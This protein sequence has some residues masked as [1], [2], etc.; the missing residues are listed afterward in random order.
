MADQ[1]P[2]QIA[3]AKAASDAA[4]AAVANPWYHGTDADADLIGH[5]ETKGWKTLTPAAAA[6]AAAKAHREAEKMVGVPAN[7]LIR[8]PKDAS[9]IAG[10]NAVWTRLGAPT[11][12]KEY[13]FADV[14]F[15]NGDALD[16]GF[17][18]A[19][20]KTAADYH[21]TKDAAKALANTFAKALDGAEAGESAEYTSALAK[22]KDTLAANWGANANANMVIAQNAA[23][24]LGV[25]PEDVKVLEK[26]IGYARVMEMFRTVGTK[27]GEDKFI[28]SGAPAGGLMTRGQ[29]VSR[30]NDLMGDKDWTKRYLDG[31]VKEK[32]EMTDLNKIIVAGMTERG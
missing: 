26:G 28:T 7:Q 9:D 12:P 17:I 1:T 32:Q 10:W 15:A 21:L 3:A 2:E 22:E 24:A 11:D 27:I 6:L 20:R 4:A 5:I 8:L 13:D 23:R 30:K 16:A 19:V 25:T 14:K 18:E 29:A 31:G